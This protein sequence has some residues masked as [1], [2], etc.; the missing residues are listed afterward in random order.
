MEKASGVLWSGLCGLLFGFGLIVSGMSNPAKILNFL[1]L[2]GTWDPSLLLVMAGAV[3]VG[4]IGYRVVLSRGV[5]LFDKQFW[6]SAGGAVDLPL[7]AG[8]AIFGI[9]WGLGGFC[10]GPALTSLLLLAPGT[11]AF[12]GAMLVAMMIG[13]LVGR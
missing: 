8:A 1:D 12:V 5:P 10:P 9:G 3:A 11:I 2:A 6:V 4:L 13:R 7:V